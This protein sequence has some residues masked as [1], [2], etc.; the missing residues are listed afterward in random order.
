MNCRVELLNFRARSIQQS[1][2]ANSSISASPYTQRGLRGGAQVISI[3]DTG[4]DVQN[5]YFSDVQGS[6]PPSDLSTPAYDNK[7]R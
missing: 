7:Y 4:V 6:V 5:C 2:T 1:A 3:A